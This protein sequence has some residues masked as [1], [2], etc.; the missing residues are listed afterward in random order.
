MRRHPPRWFWFIVTL[1]PFSLASKCIE[2]NPELRETAAPTAGPDGGSLTIAEPCLE[3]NEAHLRV[4]EYGYY[5][6]CGCV[7]PPTENPVNAS[8]TCTVP[9]GTTVYWHFAGSLEHNVSSVDGSFEHSPTQLRGVHSHTFDVPGSYPYR[10]SV[11][12]ID[13]SGFGIVVREPE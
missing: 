11:H 8:Y 6:E 13:M 7:E 9:V 10:C 5:I 1:V 2:Y 4:E 3:P 12:P